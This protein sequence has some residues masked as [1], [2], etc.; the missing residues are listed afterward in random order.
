MTGDDSADLWR[1]VASAADYMA[2]VHRPGF[3]V[4]DALEE[5]I[6]SWTDVCDGNASFRTP[7]IDPDPLRTALAN[8]LASLAMADAPGGRQ[9]SEVLA[10][11][12]ADWL[13]AASMTFNSG[14]QFSVV[15]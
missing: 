4:W 2:M 5:A 14:H 10:S 8:Q 7:W 15:E 6:R 3:T 11:S 9:F 1:R 13:V 12:L